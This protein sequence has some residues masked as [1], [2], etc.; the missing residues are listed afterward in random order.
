MDE[1]PQPPTVFDTDLQQVGEIYAK[2]L[3]AVGSDS[4]KVDVL[5]DQLGE[6]SGAVASVPS[7]KT[8]LES[9]RIDPAAKL[10]LLEKAFQ[11]KVEPSLLNFLKVLAKKGRFGCLASAASAA[12]RLRDDAAGRVQAVLTTASVVDDSIRERIAKRLSEVIGQQVSLTAQVDPAVIGGV[13]VRVGDTVYDG[14]V[15]NQLS[16]VRAKAIDRASNAIREKLDRFA[17]SG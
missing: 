4:G 11:G 7:L 15:V 6:V 9:P 2:A 8:A 17:S 13:V 5:V 14:S 10:S 12:S 3:L 1:T 16:Q